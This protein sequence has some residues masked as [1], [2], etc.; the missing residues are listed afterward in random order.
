VS[1]AIVKIHLFTLIFNKRI[2]KRKGIVK[3]GLFDLIFVKSID[4]KRVKKLRI[5]QKKEPQLTKPCINKKIEERE[6]DKDKYKQC[7]F[8][9]IV[10]LLY[11]AI[12]HSTSLHHVQAATVQACRVRHNGTEQH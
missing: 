3:L 1:F 6:R 8:I 11:T 5:F 10:H 4:I 9:I 12:M 7:W 2:K